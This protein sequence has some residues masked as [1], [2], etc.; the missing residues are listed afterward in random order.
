M[1]GFTSIILILVSIAIFFFFI[2]PRYKQIQSIQAQID[3]NKRTLEIS[4][5]LIAQRTQL[6]DKFKQISRLEKEEL[7]KLLPD[8][9][10][11]VRLIIDIDTIAKQSGIV[12]RDIDIKTQDTQTD[13]SARRSTTQTSVFEG[14]D[15]AIQYVDT[16]RI[17]VIS[18]S[19]SASADYQTFL[20]FLKQ[21]EQSR[22]IIDIREI[23]LERGSVS[24][25]GRPF[26][27]YN[28]TFDTYWLK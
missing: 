16:T 15:S 9:V 14:S 27:D 26:F 28:V 11:N 20:D 22:R 3:E 25:D 5:R 12:I 8:T 10:D 19:F 2:D 6:E 7:E 23:Q 1:K 4:K 13:T 24:P 18:F 21:L 17:G